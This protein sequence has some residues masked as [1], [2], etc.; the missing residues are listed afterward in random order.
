[1]VMANIYFECEM[2]DE[3]F[4]ELDYLLSL[5]TFF[6]VNALNLDP[7]LN[8]YRD[9]PRYIELAQKYGDEYGGI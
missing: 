4:D 6:T 2:L 7:A 9:H 1:M 3:A 8:D 5:E